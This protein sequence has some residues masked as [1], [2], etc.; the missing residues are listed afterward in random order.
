M[1]EILLK[2]L[3]DEKGQ[4][5]VEF[6]LILI[7]LLLIV[8]GIVEFGRAWY[9]ADLLKG[10]ANIAAR[11]YAVKKSETE[12]TDAAKGVAGTQVTV[13][14]SPVLSNRTTSVT[15]TVRE[16]F[17]TVVPGIL[18]ILGNITTIRR[19]ATYRIEQ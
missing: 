14:F 18:P 12:A 2:K 1:K 16:S 7:V 4:N 6:A 17:K 19:S 8:Y 9:R 11:T 3:K 13:T 15:A 10:A 5:L